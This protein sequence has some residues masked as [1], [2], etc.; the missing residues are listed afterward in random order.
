MPLAIKIS[1]CYIKFSYFFHCS[2]QFSWKITI[3]KTR[4]KKRN[5]LLCHIV[6]A[7]KTAIRTQVSLLKAHRFHLPVLINIRTLAKQYLET[8]PKIL[9]GNLKPIIYIYIYIS[10]SFDNHLSYISSCQLLSHCL[11]LLQI[12]QLLFEC[13][14]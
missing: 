11:E 1:F 2:S 4:E 12:C 14:F 5:K 8:N 6:E 10:I 13:V 3:L 9:F 7:C